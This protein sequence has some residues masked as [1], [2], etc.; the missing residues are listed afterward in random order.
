M[1]ASREPGNAAYNRVVAV[2]LARLEGCREPVA[3]D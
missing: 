1:P 3:C 2:E